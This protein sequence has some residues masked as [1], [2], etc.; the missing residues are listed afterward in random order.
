[1]E[2]WLGEPQLTA[3]FM[4]IARLALRRPYTLMGM[5][6]D[7]MAKRV[8]IV[9]ELRLAHWALWGCW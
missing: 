8:A 2:N 5:S 4:W 3:W 6:P 1:L 9:T 7:D